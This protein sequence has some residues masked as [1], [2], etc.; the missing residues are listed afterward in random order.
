M[1]HFYLYLCIFFSVIH[2]FSPHLTLEKSAK[3][4]DPTRSDSDRCVWCWYS[5]SA[6]RVIFH[7]TLGDGETPCYLWGAWGARR[8]RL[9][10]RGTCLIGRRCHLVIFT[11]AAFALQL[12]TQL[13]TVCAELCVSTH[14]HT[15]TYNAS[16]WRN[17]P[18]SNVLFCMINPR[19]YIFQQ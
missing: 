10:L 3:A 14:T 16:S 12:S 6:R 11:Q 9:Y 13:K 7:H 2:R 8:E 19:F 5:K 18:Q 1:E 4:V 17:P 15:H